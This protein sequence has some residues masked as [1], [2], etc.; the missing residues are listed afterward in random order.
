MAL[1]S[2]ITFKDLPE[3][4][5]LYSLISLMSKIFFSCLLF[6]ADEKKKKAIFLQAYPRLITDKLNSFDVASKADLLI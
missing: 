3:T 4:K 2:E 6:L 1:F 5:N